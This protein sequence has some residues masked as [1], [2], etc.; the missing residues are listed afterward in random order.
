MS[1][2]G[3]GATAPDSSFH[4]GIAAGAG[5]EYALTPN[6]ILRGQYMHLSFENKDVTITTSAGVPFNGFSARY[7]ASAD[8]AQVGVSYKPW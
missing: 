5:L 1:P 7:S 6:W 4:A 2:G 3:T 8:I